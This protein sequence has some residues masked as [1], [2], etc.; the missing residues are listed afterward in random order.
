L[1]LWIERYEF[2]NFK[3]EF[4]SNGKRKGNSISKLANGL[5]VVRTA[6]VN[7]HPWH[8]YYTEHS[9]PAHGP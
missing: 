2:S 4:K 8:G 6:R 5:K 3:L 9:L 1:E 7:Q